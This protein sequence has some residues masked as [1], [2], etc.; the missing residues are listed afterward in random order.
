[1]SAKIGRSATRLF[2]A[3]SWLPNLK[4]RLPVVEV[5]FLST[6]AHPNFAKGEADAEIAFSISPERQFGVRSEAIVEPRV[7]PVASQLSKNRHRDRRVLGMGLFSCLAGS[8]AIRS[9]L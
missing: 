5:L 8:T 7:V 2:R 1:M 6:L 4:R 9:V 3:L